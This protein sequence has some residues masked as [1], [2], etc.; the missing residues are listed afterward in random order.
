VVFKGHCKRHSL[1][2]IYLGWMNTKNYICEQAN[3]SSNIL[4]GPK[5]EEKALVWLWWQ[6]LKFWE[7]INCYLHDCQHSCQHCLQQTWIFLLSV[8]AL[9]KALELLKI[10]WRIVTPYIVSLLPFECHSVHAPSVEICCGTP[11]E[12]F[13][14]ERQTER[15]I[16]PTQKAARKQSRN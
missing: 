3:Q 2:T 1:N 13:L 4:K 7:E 11:L 14:G 15:G 8:A 5:E 12:P 10:L 9:Q 6:L 16:W